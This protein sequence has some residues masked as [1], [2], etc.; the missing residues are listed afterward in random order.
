MGITTVTA[1]VV[2]S[3]NEAIS[4]AVSEQLSTIGD[5]LAAHVPLIAAHPRLITAASSAVAAG[6]LFYYLK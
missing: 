3:N 2:A 1:G 6:G 4:S 5:S